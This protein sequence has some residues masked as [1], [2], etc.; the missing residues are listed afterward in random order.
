MRSNKRKGKS[1]RYPNVT[2]QVRYASNQHHCSKAG[3]QSFIFSQ[4]F[5]T[6][7]KYISSE[8]GLPS[9]KPFHKVGSNKAVFYLKFLTAF[10]SKMSN[11][12]YRMTM[13]LIKFHILL[14]EAHSQQRIR[15]T[16]QNDTFQRRIRRRILKF[17]SITRKL[18]FSCLTWAESHLGPLF[19]SCMQA[20]A[21]TQFYVATCLLT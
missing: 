1:P 3:T 7:A 21:N 6:T 12:V 14:Y 2:D 19:V 9:P 13:T 15:N 18:T 11:Q 10:A 17:A 8:L 4:S 5:T 16:G 20:L